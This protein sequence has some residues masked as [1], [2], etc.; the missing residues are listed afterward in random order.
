MYEYYVNVVFVTFNFLTLAVL[1]QNEAL[2][3]LIFFQ[4]GFVGFFSFN[5]D[6]S[7]VLCFT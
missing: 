1:S 3:V 6:T 7:M 2:L 5:Q 4:I